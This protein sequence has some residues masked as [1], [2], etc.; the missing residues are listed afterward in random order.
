MSEPKVHPDDSMQFLIATPRAYT[1]AEAAKVHPDLADPPAHDAFTR[2]LHRLEPDPTELW[3][4]SRHHVRLGDGV[5]VLDDSTL[6]KPHAESIGLVTHHWS[7]RHHAVVRG[8]N[9]VTLLWTDGDRNVP[10]DDRLNDR[11]DGLTKNGHFAATVRAAR[12]RGFK[13]RCVAFDG[14]YGSPDNLRSVG[15][16][17]WPWLTRLESNRP[18]D[19][20]RRGTKAVS[21]TAIAADGTE[22]W[23]PGFGLVKVFGIAAPNGGTAYW[24]TDDLGMTGLERL[25]VADCSWAIEHYHRGIKQCTG[26]ERCQCRAARAQRNHIGLAL[27]VFLGLE[28]HCFARGELG[29]GEGVNHSRRRQGVPRATPYSPPTRRFC[30]T[31]TSL[32]WKCTDLPIQDAYCLTA[33][34]FRNNPYST[35]HTTGVGACGRSTWST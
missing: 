13:P 11:A 27:R 17:G 29:G 22:V 2:L 12:A 5:L 16:L 15:S 34:V 25:R 19:L 10:R 14:R 26:I 28:V 20:D 30:V 31:P 18:V 9:R 32:T 7:G 4:E 6:D 3:R 24:A 33:R 1:A 8:I 23:L 21:A 35:P